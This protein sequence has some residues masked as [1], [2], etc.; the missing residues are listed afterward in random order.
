[1]RQSK[2]KANKDM[3]EREKEVL[4][5]DFVFSVYPKGKAQISL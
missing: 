1:M 5:E 2:N 4:T 3:Y